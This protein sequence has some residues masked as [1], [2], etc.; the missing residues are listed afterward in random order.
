MKVLLERKNNKQLIDF[1]ET[2]FRIKKTDDL[3]PTNLN[4][5]FKFLINCKK[6]FELNQTLL[7]KENELN[8]L[9][10]RTKFTF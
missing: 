10:A 9:A 8:S 3:L 7:K 2:D 5:Y 4:K 6:T 1:A